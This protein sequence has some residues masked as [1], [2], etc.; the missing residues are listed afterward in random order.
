M[1]RVLLLILL[2][3]SLSSQAQELDDVFDDGG[4]S[5]I[6]NNVYF[7][8]SDISEGYL[9]IGYARY[10]G[11]HTSV[12]FTFGYHLFDGYGLNYLAG[13]A[14]YNLGKDVDWD[15]GYLLRLS[16][17]FSQMHGEGFYTQGGI[18]F[19]KRTNEVAMYKFF[20]FPEYKIGYQL[21]LSNR[22]YA[23]ASIGIGIGV[24]VFG[25]KDGNYSVFDFQDLGF[26]IP[27]NIDLCYDL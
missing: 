4:L 20:S 13:D 11:E 18:L 14:P 3:F 5:N 19:H 24:G 15:S 6:K 1:K 7:S 23:S 25:K 2:A 22:L 8:I 17:R 9:N 27:I 26:Y 21:S 12:G 10:L 16:V